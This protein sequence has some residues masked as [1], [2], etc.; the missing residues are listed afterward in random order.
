MIK[1]IQVILIAIIIFIVLSLPDT[2]TAKM[3]KLEGKASLLTLSGF[4]QIDCKVIE[5]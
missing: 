3:C 4:K 2:L 5:D 1:L